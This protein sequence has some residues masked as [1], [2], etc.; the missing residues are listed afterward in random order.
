MINKQYKL[1]TADDFSSVFNFKRRFSSQ[2]FFL[3][4]A[5]NKF[6]N[7]RVAVIVS[8]KVAK[9]AVKRNYMKRLVLMYTL[10]QFPNL[11]Q[12]FDFV[13]RV[14]ESFYRHDAQVIK[15]EIDSLLSKVTL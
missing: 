12:K 6:N 9:L 3:H 8:K 15:S 7:D 5:P 4:L 14:K 13:F 11:V 2:H 10:H 1:L